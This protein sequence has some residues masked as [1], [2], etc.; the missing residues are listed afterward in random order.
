[1]LIVSSFCEPRRFASMIRSHR[2]FA[3]GCVRRIPLNRLQKSVSISGLNNTKDFCCAEWSE[4]PSAFADVV[5]IVSL[6][7][8]HVAEL[9]I[10]CS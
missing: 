5:V 3:L 7:E 2:S 8:L 10:G 9:D 1:M 4:F 6:R